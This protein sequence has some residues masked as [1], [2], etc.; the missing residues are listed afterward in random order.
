MGVSIIARSACRQEEAQGR[1]AVVP[2]ENARMTR[3]ISMVYQ[4]DFSHPDFLEELRKLY[5]RFS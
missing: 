1:L 4:K 5:A 3:E 2:I